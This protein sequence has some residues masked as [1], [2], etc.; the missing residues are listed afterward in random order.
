MH[1]VSMKKARASRSRKAKSLTQRSYR[2]PWRRVKIGTPVPQKQE[3][4]GFSSDLRRTVEG[5]G[6]E[7]TGAMFVKARLPLFEKLIGAPSRRKHG[8]RLEIAP[9]TFLITFSRRQS[10]L[11]PRESR[12]K[13]TSRRS[14]D[15]RKETKAMGRR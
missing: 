2:L 1:R 9:R 12:E 5:G 6:L 15:G 11:Q 14:D 3:T 4:L 10:V 13:E 8:S 7:K